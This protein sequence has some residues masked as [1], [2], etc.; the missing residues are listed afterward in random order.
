MIDSEAGLRSLY[1]EPAG[2]T[3]KK[4]LDHLDRHCRHF[5]ALCP[6]VVLAT[7]SGDG[8]LDASP[9][10]G[11]AGFIHIVDDHTLWLP[12]ARGNNRL[13]SL[14]NVVETGRVGLLAMIPGVD[15][16]LRINGTARIRDDAGPLAAFESERIPPRT[17]LEITVEQ[18]F[19][20]CA[21]AFMRS[22]L[23]DAESQISR[24]ALPTMGEMLNDQTGSTK[25][26][27]TQEQM[28]ARYAKDL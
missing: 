11:E 21:K 1:P 8:R 20:H 17:V 5:L 22:R 23:W 7:A 25:P 27:E 12:D 26:V 13:D 16:T 9:R 4:E 10:G 15:E 19:L 6:F 2:R 14:T 3:L 24:D 28:C 18:A